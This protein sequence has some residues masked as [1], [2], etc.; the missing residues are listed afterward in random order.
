VLVG[1]VGHYDEAHLDRLVAVQ[2]L[3]DR[4]F[5]LTAVAALIEADE[6]G[7]T[8]SDVIGRR[9]AAGDVFDAFET[10]GRPNAL[11]LALVPEPVRRLTG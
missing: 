9:R 6:R 5:S 11:R 2:R 10:A 4:G 1:R 8:L 7:D 3:R